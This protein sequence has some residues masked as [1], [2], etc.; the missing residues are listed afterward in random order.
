MDFSNNVPLAELCSIKTGKLD[1]NQSVVNGSYP[2]FTCSKE[3]LM[4]NDYA[5]DGEAILIAGNGDL[6]HTRYYRGKFN[7][8][9]RTYVIMDAFANMRYLKCVIDQ[10]LPA[11]IHE[12]SQGGA[13]P[14]IKLS[15]LATLLVP[16]PSRSL[17]DWI[18]E[19][20]AALTNKIELAEESLIKLERLKKGI[21]SQ[22]FI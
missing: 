17:Q 3:T 21:I 7:A 6:G 5:F 22:L 11:K 14:Y 15:T 19:F 10:L 2:F 13:M 1:A 18:A 16:V 12:E 4:I 9:Q 20:D 8:Y